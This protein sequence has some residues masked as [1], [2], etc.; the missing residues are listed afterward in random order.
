MRLRL[1][2]LTL[3]NFYY[4]EIKTLANITAK[5]VVSGSKELTAAN[6]GKL[7][8]LADK[9]DIALGLLNMVYETVGMIAIFAARSKDTKDIVL[10]G[11][12]S[13]LPYAAE[14]FPTL[15]EMFG[16]NFI[17]PE[18]SPFSTVIGTALCANEKAFSDSLS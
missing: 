4:K 2:R 8:D 16:V 5:D 12:L 7:S 6:F 10:T 14:I 18:N 13:N 11:N 9:S 15:T 1:Q 17:I 3:S